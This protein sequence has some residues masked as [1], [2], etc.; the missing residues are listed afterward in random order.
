[1]ARK[2]SR[3]PR[4]RVSVVKYGSPADGY[5]DRWLVLN[6]VAANA[7]AGS[8]TITLPVHGLSRLVVSVEFTRSA[9]TAVV[10]TP[11]YSLDDGE[12]Y[13]RLTS[14]S[15]LDGAGTVSTYSDTRTTSA[16]ENIGLS[17]DVAGMDYFKI[18]FTVTGGGASDLLTVLVS[19]AA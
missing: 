10:L 6:G 1:M 18:V 15:V 16:S 5:R 19:G 13:A 2:Q 12:T 4:Q 3:S 14:T 17:Y 7:A 11:S 9:G 8:R